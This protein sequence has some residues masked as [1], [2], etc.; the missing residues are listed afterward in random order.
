MLINGSLDR[1]RVGKYGAEGTY[2][3]WLTP[4]NPFP[5]NLGNGICLKLSCAHT[6]LPICVHTH[7]EASAIISAWMLIFAVYGSYHSCC[8]TRTLFFAPCSVITG[9]KIC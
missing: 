4:R 7:G 6:I 8:M 2:L 3:I 9:D 5:T 1:A